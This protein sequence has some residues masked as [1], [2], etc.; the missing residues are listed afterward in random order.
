MHSC[1]YVVCIPFFILTVLLPRAAWADWPQWRGPNRDDISTEIGLQAAWTEDGPRRVW[2][3]EDCGVGY[4]GPAI[5]GDRLYTLGGRNGEEQLICLDTA[6]GE[7]VWSTSLGPIYENDW[8][9][10]PRCTPTIDGEEIYALAAGGN[11]VCLQKADGSVVWTKAMQDLGGEI[12]NWGYAESPLVLEDRVLCTPGGEQGA[13]AAV[14]KNTGELLW[15]CEEVTDRAH[16]S[17]LVIMEHAGKTAAVQLLEKQLVGVDVADGALLWTTPWTGR[18]AVVPTPIVRG[19]QVYATSGYGAG[20]LLVTIDN[21]QSVERVYEN[22]VMG[23]H[24]GGVILV[25]D[26]VYGHSDNKGWTCQDFATGEKIWQEKEVFGKGAIAYAN[27]HFYCLSE[28]EGEVALV[29]AS[30]EGWLEQGRF[31]LEPQTELR[32]PRGKIWTH[33][34]I[35]GGRLYLRD[36]NL[37]YC[38][39]VANKKMAARTSGNTLS[40]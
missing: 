18:V 16:Y 8:G 1:R 40:E 37:L 30:P 5:V 32:K 27:G 21:D 25:G 2:M 19:N 4:S 10:G 17:S 3:F 24:H 22:K 15:Q 26:H 36:Q 39:D 9:D 20:C 35:D 31:K 14:D 7:E 33:P 29:A 38:Y 11:L 6:N 23:D 13:I 12:P 34:V 28:D